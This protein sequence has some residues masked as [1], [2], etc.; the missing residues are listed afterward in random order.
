MSI[1]KR[2]SILF[3]IVF[4]V[5]LV[6]IYVYSL[7]VLPQGVNDHVAA[8]KEE[9]NTTV[10]SVMHQLE[11]SDDFYTSVDESVI[12]DGTLL[13]IENIDGD[14]VYTYPDDTAREKINKDSAVYVTAS[15]K[16]LSTNSNGQQIYFIK[17]AI[18]IT[19]N[20][21]TDDRIPSFMSLYLRRVISF[22]AILFTVAMIVILIVIGRIIIDPIEK[23]TASIRGYKKNVHITESDEKNELK[24]LSNDFEVL[25][26]S[27]TEEQEKQTRIIA[28]V[29]HDIKTPLTSIMGY[30][31]Q[32]KKDS[33]SIERKDRYVNTIYEKSMAIK[34]MIE[35]LDDYLTYNESETSTEKVLIPV[36]QLLVAVDSYYRDDLEREK[37]EFVVDDQSEDSVIVI[38]KADM[39]RVFGNI[40]S[41]STK[42]RTGDDFKI[43]IEAVKNGRDI[44]FRVSDNGKGVEEWQ[45]KKIFEP[46][47]TTDPSRSK[48][49]SGLG[50]SISKDIVE[51]HQGRMYAEKS[52]FETGLSIIFSVPVANRKV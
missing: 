44:V 35:G 15:E 6:G 18:T 32:L 26:K 5:N 9:I 38:N 25:T 46:L 3:L 20:S 4:F 43:H 50:L 34:R 10:Q 27:I 8:I 17:G 16:F 31:E 22:E 42:H 33:I 29:S 52:K 23:L 2:I 30:A 37:C 21:M 14:V 1:R 39:L 11:Y 7:I 48:S 41:N 47:Y 51:A 45:L 19:D 40:I 36:K 12:K 24:A 49:V 28:S 13:Y